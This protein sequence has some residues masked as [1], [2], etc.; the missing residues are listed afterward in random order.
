MLKKSK[1]KKFLNQSTRKN[2]E[3]KKTN[4]K[5]LLSAKTQYYYFRRGLPISS[6]NSR[7][8]S[9]SKVTY[10]N[11]FKASIEFNKNSFYYIKAPSGFRTAM[12]LP[13]KYFLDTQR[14]TF[15]T[16]DSIPVW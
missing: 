5:R 1:K 16:G 7:I 8:N 6:F 3:S 10:A 14:N 15:V 9:V 12:K 13:R 4:R 2:F 11:F